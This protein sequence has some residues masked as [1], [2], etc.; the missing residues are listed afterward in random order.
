MHTSRPLALVK[1]FWIRR[2]AGAVFCS[3][4]HQCKRFCVCPEDGARGKPTQLPK[5]VGL[6]LYSQTLF[7]DA[8]TLFW[9]LFSAQEEEEHFSR[10]LWH[11]VG[12]RAHAEAGSVQA[13]DT[14]DEGSAEEEGRGGFGGAGGAG[15]QGGQSG[16]LMQLWIHIHVHFKDYVLVAAG[17]P[18][19]GAEGI[20]SS[21]FTFFH[22]TELCH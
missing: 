3:R 17:I 18:R 14:E 5:F 16:G 11:Q 21:C 22:V 4:V 2:Y 6:Q 1:C 15:V 8:K 10:C 7:E 19:R 9:N 13:A 12:P 20:C